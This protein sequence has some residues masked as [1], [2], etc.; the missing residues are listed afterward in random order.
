MFSEEKTAKEYF[1]KKEYNK[2]L[3]IFIKEDNYYAAGLCYLLLKDE[4]NAKKFWE[5]NKKHC[6]ACSFGLC[7]LRLIHLK[8]D[9]LPTFFQ[10]RAQ[11]EIYLNLFIQNNLIEWAENVIACADFLYRANPESYKFIARALYSNGYF[12]LAIVFCKKTLR[13]C[14]CD[15]EAFLILSQCYFLKGD[16]GEALDCVNRTLDMVSDYYPAI[17]FK[18]IIKDKIDKKNNSN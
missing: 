2:A 5:K 17:L 4:K 10:T 7:V 14:Y 8:T 13:L 6:P 16:N 12:D 3:E 11:L 18:K 1:Y 15:P 9:K